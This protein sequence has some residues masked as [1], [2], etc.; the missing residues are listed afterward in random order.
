MVRVSLVKK[1]VMRKQARPR[2]STS[3][4]EN[5]NMV[6]EHRKFQGM[7]MGGIAANAA[8]VTPQ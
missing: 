1:C 8:R 7:V 5:S 3:P 6:G 2:I 4:R